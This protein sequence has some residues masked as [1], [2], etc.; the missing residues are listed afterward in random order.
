MAPV[1]SPSIYVF[2]SVVRFTYPVALRLDRRVH[3]SACPF[4]VILRRRCPGFGMGRPVKPDGDGGFRPARLALF[5]ARASDGGG[6]HPAAP[7][8]HIQNTC[9]IMPTNEAA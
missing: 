7:I 3:L 5:T 6:D 8:A 4:G 9:M 1:L 2:Q